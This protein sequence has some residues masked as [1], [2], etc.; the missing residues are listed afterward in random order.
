M[1]QLIQCYYSFYYVGS[2]GGQRLHPFGFD[3]V[4]IFGLRVESVGCRALG[5]EGLFRLA[6][7]AAREICGTGRRLVGFGFCRF[8]AFGV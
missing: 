8:A 1:L 4:G 7:R 5:H 6:W 2:G 3:F